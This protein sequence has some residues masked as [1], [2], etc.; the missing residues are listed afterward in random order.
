MI[1]ASIKIAELKKFQE[2]CHAY[3]TL[4]RQYESFDAQKHDFEIKWYDSKP[5]KLSITLANPILNCMFEGLLD[6]YTKLQQEAKRLGIENNQYVGVRVEGKK[7][8]VF[9]NLMVRIGA[10]HNLAV[11]LDT[12]E[13][14]AACIDKKTIGKLITKKKINYNKTI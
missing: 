5:S 7:G 13:G 12:D 3:D 4:K 10:G 6:M 9:D 2:E 8:I 1:T 11:H 14:N